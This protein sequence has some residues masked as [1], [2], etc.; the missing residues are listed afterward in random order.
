MYMDIFSECVFVW[1]YVCMLH[2]C[3]AWGRQK[4]GP[5]PRLL[6][7]QI[8]VSLYMGLRFKPWSYGRAAHA[9]KHWVISLGLM[10]LLKG[11][12]YL[13]SS[14]WFPQGM[15]LVSLPQCDTLFLPQAHSGGVKRLYQNKPFLLRSWN[16]LREFIAMIQSWITP[17]SHN[18]EFYT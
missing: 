11:V 13:Q 7:F 2:A 4:R 17:L 8:V 16:Y 12:L 18:Q 15:W 1:M 10:T 3:S 6:E 9:L 5:D 14:P